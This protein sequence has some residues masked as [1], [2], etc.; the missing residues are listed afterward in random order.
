M[1]FAHLFQYYFT[2]LVEG[3]KS[4]RRSNSWEMWHV[5]SEGWLVTSTQSERE[6]HQ[7][8]QQPVIRQKIPVRSTF[9]AG[10]SWHSIQEAERE[11]NRDIRGGDRRIESQHSPEEYT[12][13][14]IVTQ[15]GHIAFSSLPPLNSIS[16]DEPSLHH[17]SF[18]EPLP[19]F[20]TRSRGSIGS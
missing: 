12:S 19:S 3:K 7:R 18:R 8:S 1:S 20:H 6:T 9:R 16:T 4:L 13:R 10:C 17:M 11:R 15:L 5:V 2:C 14:D